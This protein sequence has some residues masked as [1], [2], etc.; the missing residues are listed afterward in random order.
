MCVKEVEAPGGRASRGSAH[1]MGFGDESPSSRPGGSG[2]V[3]DAETSQPLM[4]EVR[5]FRASVF[6]RYPEIRDCIT[7]GLRW[8]ESWNRSAGP[9]R[10]TSEWPIDI[11][12]PIWR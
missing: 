6:D 5:G 7:A 10:V 2:P 12:W 9:T 4:P 3:Y 11:T 1:E 8:I